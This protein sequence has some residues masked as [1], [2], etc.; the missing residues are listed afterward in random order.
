MMTPFPMKNPLI[1]VFSLCLTIFA[2]GEIKLPTI[3]SDHMVLQQKQVNPIWG[4]DVPGTKVIVTF[5][6]Q[7]HRA[8]AGDD[9]KWTVRLSPLEADSTPQN[10]TVEGTTK[11]E[12]KDVLIGEVWVCSGQSNMEWELAKS[13]NGDL[14]SLTATLPELRLITVAVKGTQ[15]SLTDFS[16]EWKPSTPETALQ[17]SAVGF[18]FG[19]QLHQTLRVPVGLIANPWGGAPAE[20]FIRRESI[21]KDP[22]FKSISESAAKLE[23]E[24][25]PDNGEADIAR[26]KAEHEA[27]VQKAK[28]EK[29]APP[30]YLEQRYLDNKN[31]PGNI[32]G[33]MIHP[34][35]GY[36]MKGVIWYQ[37]ESNATRAWEYRELFPFLIQEWRREWKQGDFPFYWVQLA[38]HQ[39]EGSMPPDSALAELRDAQSSALKLPNTGQAVTIDIGEGKDIHPRNKHD[40]AA[41]LVRWALAKDYGFQIPFRSPEFK[42]LTIE[43]S[44]AKV[45]LDCFG[46]KLRPFDVNEPRGLT[47]CGADQK[48]QLAQGKILNGDTIEVWSDQVPEPVAVRYAW[49]SNPICNLYSDDG[50]PVTPFRTDDFPL[51]TQPS[52]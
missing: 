42:N 44:K 7:E 49:A 38:D 10:L 45:T 29:K 1:P 26:Q 3:I 2:R 4:W 14:D 24:L 9:G 23:S 6:D 31:R 41:R 18:R 20:A 25:L 35:V 28:E 43:G 47:I 46:S 8:V 21:D 34:V 12:I 19:R 51:K 33:G 11:R 39:A 48:W 17:F 50:L 37:G 22:R 27:A 52:P 13:F 5:A 32:F 30:K 40:V 15:E 16:G 36:G